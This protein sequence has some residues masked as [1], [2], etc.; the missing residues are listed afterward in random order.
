MG[1]ILACHTDISIVTLLEFRAW[2][3]VIDIR[4]RRV[5]CP[6]TRKGCTRTYSSLSGNWDVH[7]I[8]EKPCRS[9]PCSS[10]GESEYV[11]TYFGQKMCLD[12]ISFQYDSIL[13]LMSTY[14]KNVTP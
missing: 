5:Q 8:P 9:T 11:H 10:P 1:I 3:I 12:A 6:R 14:K 2:V 13:I 4:Y 7:Y